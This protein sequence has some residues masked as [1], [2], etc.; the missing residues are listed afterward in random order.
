MLS[1][2]PTEHHE[3]QKHYAVVEGDPAYP[4]RR[5]RRQGVPGEDVVEYE[6]E[7]PGLESSEHDLTEQQE[8]EQCEPQAIRTQEGRHPGQQRRLA[9]GRACSGLH[10]GSAPARACSGG[11]DALRGSASIWGMV[12]ATSLPSLGSAT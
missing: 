7:R 3:H 11:S 2:T 6:R 12:S 10:H 5:H 9:A 8:R 4:I 1:T